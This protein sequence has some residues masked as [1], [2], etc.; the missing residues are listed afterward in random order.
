[1][2]NPRH[3]FGFDDV[4]LRLGRR[5]VLEQVHL[6]V[7]EGDRWFLLG[8][9]GAGK[10]TFLRAL[11]GEIRPAV[12]SITRSIDCAA[13]AHI[14]YVPQHCAMDPTLPTT[15]EEF[16][17]IGLTGL[18]L[19]RAQRIELTQEALASVDLSDRSKTSLWALSHGQR[20]RV[21]LARALARR[22]KTLLL[23]EPTSA[24]DPSAASRFWAAVT[25]ISDR[26]P[27][28]MICVSH[29]LESAREHATHVALFKNCEVQSGTAE[30]RLG[31]AYIAPL[32]G[33][34]VSGGRP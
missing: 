4:T 33:G 31:E 10:T 19:A 18:R 21:L 16:V 23:D 25:R 13:P 12:G 22:P 15:V 20:Q 14:G 28:T 11:T 24:L 3:V 6:S 29:D 27:M 9:N 32:F 5:T 2:R 26:Q 1:M 8:P 30:E 17:E 34:G 7:E